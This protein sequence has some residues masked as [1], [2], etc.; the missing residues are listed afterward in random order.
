MI[1]PIC[2]IRAYLVAISRSSACTDKSVEFGGA[3]LTLLRRP[4]KQCDERFESP[5]LATACS[6]SKSER[7]REAPPPSLREC[8]APKARRMSQPL[9]SPTWGGWMIP[10]SGSKP[11]L[12]VETPMDAPQM[13]VLGAH[14]IFALRSPDR[15]FAPLLYTTSCW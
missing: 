12:G 3:L 15:D 4:L 6:A 1:S 5:L 7:G 9:H 2:S 13:G 10:P 8:S 14:Q 11:Y